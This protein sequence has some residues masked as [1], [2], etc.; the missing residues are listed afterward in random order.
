MVSYN[1]QKADYLFEQLKQLRDNWAVID[2][3]ASN[4]QI[5][6]DMASEQAEKARLELR[7]TQFESG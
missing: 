4:K 5:K 6:A 3:A 7:E 1:L 2:H